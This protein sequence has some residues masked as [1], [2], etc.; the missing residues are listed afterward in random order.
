MTRTE[1]KCF[2]ATSAV[3]GLLFLVLVIGPAFYTK[4]PKPEP[5][6]QFLE[7]VN[8]TDGPSRGG[9]PPPPPPEPTPPP[10]EPTPPPPKPTPPPEPK[11]VAKP[12]P[13]P[14]PKPEPKP[15][16]KPVV[17]TKPQPK[18]EPKPEPKPK[19]EPRRPNVDLNKVVKLPQPTPTQPQNRQPDALNQLQRSMEN[20]RRNA[21]SSTVVQTS[22][23]GGEAFVSYA[24]IVKQT[25]EAAW[26]PPDEIA[27]TA[28][29]VQVEV[30]I[31]RTGRVISGRILKRSGIP[32]LDKSV[33]RALELKAMPV[34]F[35]PEI[36]DSQ[37]TFIINFNL[38]AK[39]LLG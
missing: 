31:E 14:Q 3:H 21:S 1:K 6:V 26:N 19:P 8:I 24:A 22:G 35:P 5:Q 34:G 18:P 28:N 29:A 9:S 10:P 39:R 38:Q 2:Y 32:A 4:K 7:L 27:D 15:E 37:R 12:E 36:K 17:E 20:I 23:A 30:T 33:E 25:Y 13:K 11:P 16:P